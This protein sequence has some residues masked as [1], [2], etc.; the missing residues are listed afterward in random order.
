MAPGVSS[1]QD[2]EHITLE[3]DPRNPVLQTRA[4]VRGCQ[5][6]ASCLGPSLTP[7]D[8]SGFGMTEESSPEGLAVTHRS[9]RRRCAGAV[10]GDR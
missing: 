6:E 2:Q 1:I 4:L 5:N 10:I 7:P 3:N 9:G 8:Y